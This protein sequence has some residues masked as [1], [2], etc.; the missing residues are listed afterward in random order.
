MIHDA[1]DPSDHD[2]L[3]EAAEPHPPPT[4]SDVAA[5]SSTNEQPPANPQSSSDTIHA[6]SVTL[7]S[8]RLG[9]VTTLDLIEATGQRATPVDYKKGSP[10]YREDGSLSAWQPERIQ[11][12]LPALVLC[13]NGF[14]C[15]EGI[16]YFNEPRQR[17]ERRGGAD[18][19]GTARGCK[20]TEK[21]SKMGVRRCPA[22]SGTPLSVLGSRKPW[23]S[24]LKSPVRR[25]RPFPRSPQR[26]LIEAL[27]SLPT[28]S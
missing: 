3:A 20:N 21:S 28:R 17:C 4:A 18:F 16:L 12:C 9:V 14:A 23:R 11:V 19:P 6:R 26:G 7:A 25:H 5:G 24:P 10:R 2:Q 8:D 1:E 27:R 13:E 15:D 22:T